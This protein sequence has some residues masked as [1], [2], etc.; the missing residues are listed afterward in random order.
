MVLYTN[1][2]RNRTTMIKGSEDKDRQRKMP[3]ELWMGYP[4]DLS[5]L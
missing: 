4:P 3:H 1:Y 5:N 2:L